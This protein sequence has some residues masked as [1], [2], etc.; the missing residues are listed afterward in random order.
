MILDA[1]LLALRKIA[2]TQQRDVAILPEM[3]IARGDGI[4]ISHPV[5]GYEL[6]LS[7]NVDYAVIGYE[8]VMDNEG[9]SEYQTPLFQELLHNLLRP[10]AL[11]WWIQRRCI[12]DCKRSPLAS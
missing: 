12:R 7:G 5:S 11:P 2:L 4:H 10:L 3:G 6:W 9:E 8:N 1:I